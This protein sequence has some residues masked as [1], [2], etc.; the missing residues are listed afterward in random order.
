MLWE[1]VWVLLVVLL[2]LLQFLYALCVMAPSVLPVTCVGPCANCYCSSGA[3]LLVLMFFAFSWLLWSLCVL[4]VNF[5]LL[6]LFVLA[7]PGAIT[8]H[9]RGP[10]LS[11]VSALRR[12]EAVPMQMLV[13]RTLHTPCALPSCNMVVEC[14]GGPALKK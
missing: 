8:R 2:Y 5:L 4:F 9:M 11:E 10:K 14:I 7:R 12:S 6:S 1:S 13:S 3:L